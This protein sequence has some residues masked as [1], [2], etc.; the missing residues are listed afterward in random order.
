MNQA[1]QAIEDSVIPGYMA[2]S[3][4]FDRIRQQAPGFSRLA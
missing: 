2:L 1:E 4:Q 3:D